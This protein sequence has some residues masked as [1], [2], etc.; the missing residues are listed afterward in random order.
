MKTFDSKWEEVEGIL[1]SAHTPEQEIKR[2]RLIFYSGAMTLIGLQIALYE[3]TQGDTDEGQKL[4][5]GLIT[6]ISTTAHELMP[7]ECVKAF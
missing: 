3:E 6:E 1:A 5:A 2:T 4:L 7:A